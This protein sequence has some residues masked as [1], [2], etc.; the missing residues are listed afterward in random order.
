MLSR[1][2]LFEPAERERIPQAAAPALLPVCRG[3]SQGAIALDPAAP[4][5]AIPS[6]ARLAASVLLRGVAF[7]ALFAALAFLPAGTWRFWQA[8]VFGAFYVLPIIGLLLL[9]V[10]VDPETAQRRL[11]GGERDPTQRKII[12]SSWLPFLLV[13]TAPGFDYRFHWTREGLV[14]VPAWASIAADFLAL[15]GV[16][17]IAWTISVNRHAARTIRVEEG[18]QVIS[19]GPYRLVRHPMYAGLI[20]A[21]L[22]MPIAMGSIVTLPLFVL[23]IPFYLVRLLHEEK[24]LSRDL[25][26][27][28]DYC[29]RTRYRLVPFLW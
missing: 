2:T 27:Y 28:T 10:I 11:A 21:Q 7:S 1:S 8:W 16:L 14:P 29:Q 24:V 13:T 5:P 26:G 3:G 20:L 23:L 17:L 15:A 18:Q 19:S 25:P 4:A 22:A 9:L 12:R 6:R